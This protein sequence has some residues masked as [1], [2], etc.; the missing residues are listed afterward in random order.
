MNSV[1]FANN[2]VH[3]AI[4]WCQSEFGHNA[5]SVKNQF[6]SWYWTFEFQDPLQATYFALKWR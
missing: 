5:F 1:T 3:D 2:N 4:L 6:P